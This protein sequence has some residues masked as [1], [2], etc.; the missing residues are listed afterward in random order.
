VSNNHHPFGFTDYEA[1]EEAGLPRC[2]QVGPTEIEVWERLAEYPAYVALASFYVDA[3]GPRLVGLTLNPYSHLPWPPPL[4]TTAICRSAPTA[5]LYEQARGYLSIAREI[6]LTL[7]VDLTEFDRD[8]RPGKRGRADVFY[9]GVAKRY[10]ELLAVSSTPTKDL[11]EELDQTVTSTRD[12][13]HQARQRGLLT[14]GPKGIAGGELTK[15]AIG[16]LVVK[17]GEG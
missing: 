5:R 12:V 11:A 8:H 6:G 4:L 10:V 13:L 15:K 16:L 3:K 1:A 2:R 14:S 17:G 9:A 7:D